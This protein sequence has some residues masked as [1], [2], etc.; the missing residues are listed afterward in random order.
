[1]EKRMDINM[2][3]QLVMRTA[4]SV[5]V[6]LN[7]GGTYETG[8]PQPMFAG[9]ICG[10]G[11]SDV[12]LYG[13]GAVNGCACAD[14][15]WHDPK[16]MVGAYRPRMLFL[17]HCEKI[18]IQGLTFHDSPAWVVHPF[19]SNDLVFANLRSAIRSS[20]PIRTAS[21]RILP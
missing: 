11:V 9:V 5:T 14:N 12:K 16:V 19:F 20:R 7:D 21:I 3:I 1:M 2:E 18:Q 8:E 17:K 6:A 4:R 13:E 10:I 15:W